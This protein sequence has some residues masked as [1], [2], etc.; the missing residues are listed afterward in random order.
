ME[1]EVGFDERSSIGPYIL[2]RRPHALQWVSWS[3][4]GGFP[5]EKTLFGEQDDAN[6]EGAI[7]GAVT[8]SS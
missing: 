3:V 2:R 8:Y 5:T 4:G 1:N 7:N 6:F